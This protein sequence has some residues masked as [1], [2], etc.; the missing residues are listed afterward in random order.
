M[1]LP[2]LVYVMGP[3]GAGKDAV[4]DFARAAL[5]VGSP[6]AF[7][8]RYITRPAHSGGENHV[9]LSPAE[10]ASRR[11][12]GLFAFHWHAHGTDYG[13]GIE[14]ETWRRAGFVVVV[15]GSREHA[16]TLDATALGLRFVLI[17]APSEVLRQRLTGRGREPDAAIAERLAR[18]AALAVDEPALTVIDNAG[19]LDQAGRALLALLMA[20]TG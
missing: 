15:S 3:S 18:A 20:A 6:V 14:I 8:H 17:T 19:P 11:N 10:F 4:L 9:A 13:I 16:R 2:P 12:A 5:P 7:A 1:G